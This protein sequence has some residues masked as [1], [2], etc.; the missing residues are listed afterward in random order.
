MRTLRYSTKRLRKAMKCSAFLMFPGIAS[1]S[2]SSGRTKCLL[3]IGVRELFSYIIT[4]VRH[5]C[6]F[7]RFLCR[8]LQ[9]LNQLCILI[10]ELGSIGR[11]DPCKIHVITLYNIKRSTHSSIF[12]PSLVTL[13]EAESSI[14]RVRS[15]LRDSM[16]TLSRPALS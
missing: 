7:R 9:A 1:L 5:E 15:M 4:G 12:S 10:L 6:I 13:R 11:L 3:I 2:R 14:G 16:Q 8:V